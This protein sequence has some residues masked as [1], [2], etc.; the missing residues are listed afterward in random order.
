MATDLVP[1]TTAGYKKLQE[2]LKQLKNVERPQVVEAIAFARALGDLSENAEYHAAK[3]R[4]GIVE[5]RIV[6]L[7]GKL[8]KAQVIDV[9]KIHSDT[10]KFGAIVEIVDDDTD[11]VSRYQ[12][13]GSDEADVKNGLLPITSPIAKKLI[14]KAK[15][16]VVE[17]ETPNGTKTYT[18]KKIQYAQ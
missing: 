12:I 13:V 14:G 16:D 4:Q 18:V 1:M 17:V 10:I 8:S 7:E 3:D 15:N 2:E 5:A 11:I 9:S 6:E